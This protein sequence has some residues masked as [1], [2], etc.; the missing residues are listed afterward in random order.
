[1]SSILS[2]FSRHYNIYTNGRQPPKSESPI[3]FG[4][5]GA[6]KIGPRALILPA[7]QHPE[8]VVTAIAA[9]SPTKASLYAK[10]HNI[11]HVLAT[12]DDLVVSDQIDAVYIPLPN[13]LHLEWAVKA[14]RAGKHVLLEKPSVSNARE[15]EHLFNNKEMIGDRVLLEAFHYRFQPCWLLFKSLVDLERVERVRGCLFVPEGVMK[16]DDI[17]FRYDLAGGALMDLGYTISVVRGILETEPIQCTSCKVTP[18]AAPEE[19]VDMG[20]DATFEFP[21]GVTAEVHGGFQA[22]VW[23]SLMG[24]KRPTAEAVHRPV[25]VEDPS[26][27][28]GQEKV[29]TRTV[30]MINFIVGN[31]WHRID[32]VDEWMVRKKD[33]GEVVGRW[34]EKEVKKGYT[35]EE[36][37]IKGLEDRHSEEYWLSYKFQ[38]DEFIDRIKGRKGT[39]VWVSSE[40]SI[41]QMKA[42]DMAYEKSGLGV[43]EGTGFRL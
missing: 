26:L 4:I 29:R 27:P 31:L 28:E 20:Y 18:R 5:L 12:Y 3:R 43:R 35:W 34:T 13:G 8:A 7:L 38:L 24:D 6:A 22:G 25:V 19:K 23:E 21:G 11:P 40:E 42:V 17:R 36:A 15:A 30:T 33:T 14:L 41:N 9:R 2:F 32:V 16:E 37:G 10:K 39:G 1:M